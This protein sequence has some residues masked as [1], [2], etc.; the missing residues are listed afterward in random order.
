GRAMLHHIFDFASG[1]GYQS[2]VL[3]VPKE[4]PAF[5]F[6]LR[7][8]FLVEKEIALPT[9]PLCLLRRPLAE[10][11]AESDAANRAS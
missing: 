7:E 8:G 2:V 1:Q 6:Y 9:M 10:R 5:G 4:T 11:G 3:E